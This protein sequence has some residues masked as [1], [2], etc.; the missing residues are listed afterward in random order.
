MV[1][2]PGS[3]TLNDA[4]DANG[5]DKI[6][7]LTAGQWYGLTKP[8]ENV[9][10]HLQIIG[11]DVN[12]HTGTQLP[13][14]L[15]TGTDAE[16]A[17]FTVMIDAKGDLTVKNVYVMNVDLNGQTGESFVL[18]S[19]SAGSVV[20]DNCVLD[21][22]GNRFGI[23][24]LGGNNDI[25]FTNN[26][27]LRHGKMVSQADGH[28]FSLKG[29]G[30]GIDTL[31][32]ENNTFVDMGVFLTSGGW[33]SVIHNVFLLNHNTFIRHK[34]EWDSGSLENEFYHTNNLIIDCAMIPIQDATG[35]LPGK[36]P[37]FF[38]RQML[39]ADSIAG[40]V[41][42]TQRIQHIQYNNVTRTDDWFPVLK[43]W[44]DT[45]KKYE[46]D[47]AFFNPLIWDGNTPVEYGFD[48]ELGKANCK[49][50]LIFNY[51]GHVNENFPNFNFGNNT[52]QHDPM[53]TDQRIYTKSSEYAEW[54]FIIFMRDQLKYLVA[55]NPEGSLPDPTELPLWHWD[56]DGNI[57][58]NSTWPIFDGTYTDPATLTGSIEKLPLG[59]LNWY[60]AEKAKWEGQAEEI[61]EYMKAGN[62][63]QMSL[64]G[65]E[66]SVMTSES[67]LNI[68]PN[69]ARELLN[70]TSQSELNYARFYNVT[71]QMVMDINLN[72]VLS[73]DVN[74]SGLDNGLY[75]IQVQDVTGEMNSVKFMKQ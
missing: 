56:P 45:L 24:G 54:G 57:T 47:T 15:Q 58:L 49:E 30:Q 41:M 62:T 9:D 34:G 14:T 6:Y 20:V 64:T 28:M 52:Y 40:E 50:A 19:D 74:V 55:L 27:V 67:T 25:L 31:W 29:A 44:N 11:E 10:Y 35:V 16:G 22:V 13:A 63:E 3:G 36:D 59:D 38:K 48:P 8:I 61:F 4:I 18:Q 68:Y 69:P 60:P 42:P 39:F 43:N 70:I 5:G 37:D 1:V 12:I 46:V 26:L 72:G 17:P 2:P 71:G 53:F 75:I 51:P 66:S 7:L 21:P 33:G 73:Q 32:V 65:I 23:R